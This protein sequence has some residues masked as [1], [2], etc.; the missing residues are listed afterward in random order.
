M[1]DGGLALGDGAR[2]VAGLFQAEGVH[3]KQRVVAGDRGAPRRQGARDPVAQH[4][5]VA[6]EEVDL[7]T[8]VQRQR[9]KRVVDAHVFQR[10]AGIAP[11]AVDQRGNR[12]HMAS[13]ALGTCEAGRLGMAGARH[14]QPGGLGAEQ[15]Q[16]GLERMGHRHLRRGSE[17]GVDRR[18]WVADEAP[19]LVGGGFVVGEA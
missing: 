11:A 2:V 10:A 12:L 15:E 5:R 4:A 1:R 16:V 14:G 19:K 17:C 8:G 7:V 18:D 13:L 6:A 3:A 9:V